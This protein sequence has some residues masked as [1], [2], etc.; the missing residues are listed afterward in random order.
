[1]I[2]LIRRNSPRFFLTKEETKKLSKRVATFESR[3]SCEL[4]FHFRRRLGADPLQKNESLFYKFGLDKTKHR[5]GILITL[6]ISD[7][8][9]A[10]W[11]DQGVIRHTGDNL[12]HQVSQLMSH[13]LKNGK[14]LQALCAAVD[15]AEAVLAKEQPHFKD[16]S[17]KNELSNSPIIEDEE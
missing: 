17:Q 14:H 15:E 2:K 3:T 12:W 13:L 7:R 5:N 6:G 8:K 4:V 11:A 1:M 10:I 9:F 16:E